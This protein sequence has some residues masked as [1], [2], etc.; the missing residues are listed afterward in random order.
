M[1]NLFATNAYADLNL[2]GGYV[3]PRTG[4]T[5]GPHAVEMIRQ[6]SVRRSFLSVGGITERGFY[7]SNLLLTVTE[8]AM[9]AVADQVIVVADSSK[10][11]RQSLAQLCQWDAVHA[12]VV[13]DGLSDEWRDR[14]AE[15][16]TQLIVAATGEEAATPTR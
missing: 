8:Q 14:V 1:A 4:V 9:M 6:L 2:V 12:V 3:Y 10:F 7:N 11:G 13:D 15:F 5:L 16:N